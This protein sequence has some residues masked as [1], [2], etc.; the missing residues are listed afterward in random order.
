MLKRNKLALSVSAA[1]LSGGLVAPLAMAQTSGDALEEVTVTGIRASLQDAQSVKRNSVAIVDAISAEDV[2]KFPD[3]NVA[4][5]LARITGVGVTRDFGQGEKV[6]IRGAG[7]DYNRTTLNGQTVATAD[8]FILDNP[9]RSFNFTLLPSTLIKTLEVHKSPE[10]SQDEGSLG[11]TVVVRTN[12]PLDLDAN[13]ASVAVENTYTETSESWDPT[14]SGQYS[15]KNADETFGVLVAGNY[16]KRNQQRNG[17]EVL[18][19]SDDNSNGTIYPTLMGTPTF[20]QDRERSTYFVSTQFRPSDELTFTLDALNSSVDADNM[21]ANWMIL[22]DDITDQIANG[23][24]TITG[25]T[26]TAVANGS[27][28]ALVD[29]INRR[30][31]TE[32][33]SYTL[34][35]EYETDAFSL[36]GVVGHTAASGGTY[37]E[38]SW[39]Y[40]AADADYSYNLGSQSYGTNPGPTDPAAYSAGWIWGGN[41]PTTDEENYYQLDLTLPVEFGAVTAIKTGIKYRDAERTQDRNVYS[42]HGPN[43]LAGNEDKAADWPVYLGYI[44]DQCPTL[45]DCGLDSKGIVSVNSPIDGNSKVLGQARNVM[46]SIAFN[47]LNGV[48]ADYAVSKFLPEIWSVA[49]QTTAFYVQADFESGAL[50]GNAGLRYVT[51]DQASSGYTYIGDGYETVDR[52]WLSNQDVKWNTVDNDYSEIL[53][54]LNLAYD[55][56]DDMVVRGSVARVMA[57]QNWDRLSGYSTF[58]SLNVADPKGSAGNPYLD[59]TFANQVD[60]GFE[61]YYGEAS[62]F[63]TTLFYK[64]IDSYIENAYYTEPRYDEMTDTYVDVDFAAPVNGKGGKVTGVEL[65]VDH[66]FDNGFG[67]SANYTYTDVSNPQGAIGISENMANL[68]GYFE[69]D[70]FSGRLMYNYR[71]NYNNGFSF[72]GFP[73]WTEGFGQVDASFAYHINENASV[74]LEAVNLTDEEVKQYSGVEARL[75]SLYQNG[76]R[77]VVGARYKF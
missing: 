57:R 53:P 60:V 49:E 14:V 40:V 25:D 6:T 42:W 73:L 76:R 4:E 45:A 29:F 64:D 62:A 22:T 21:N 38:T 7:A 55:L 70:A 12:R 19:W 43:T 75:T 41:K 56:N 26:A 59:P 34:T 52:A 30:S 47:S 44:F 77:F 71:D 32:T 3:K 8:W 68:Q 5:S 18:G 63:S 39:E 24:A 33:E 15:W 17:F 54:S 50:R 27:G 37:R 61:W 65:A 1:V 36:T 66:G 46:E 10:A 51:T 13:Q 20:Q 16:L 72:N 28:T 11:G 74:T 48:P 31:S 9:A 2:G 67:V 35:G 23:T 69:N 58:G